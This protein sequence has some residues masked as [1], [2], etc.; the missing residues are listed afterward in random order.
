LEAFTR[1]VHSINDAH[2][3]G[4]ARRNKNA[5]GESVAQWLLL[6][7]SALKEIVALHDTR[8]TG[9]LNARSTHRPSDAPKA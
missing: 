6:P 8:V 2:A 5:Q 3:L 9:N 7:V 4:V 1:P